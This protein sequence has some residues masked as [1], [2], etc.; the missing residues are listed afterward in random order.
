MELKMP[1]LLV[2]YRRPENAIRILESALNSGVKDFYVAVDGPRDGDVSNINDIYESYLSDFQK[3]YDVT[4]KV[5]Y[6]E[7]N[8]GLAVSMLTAIDWFFSEV[9]SGI[10]LEDDLEVGREFFEFMAS[11]LNY[12]KEQGEVLAISGNQFFPKTVSVSKI[13]KS[14]YPLIWGW[15]TWRDRWETFRNQLISGDLLQI[16]AALPRKVKYFWK[17]GCLR[18]LNS[19]SNSWAILL[20]SHSRFNNYVC[21]FPSSHLS[22]NIGSDDHATHTGGGHWTMNIALGKNLPSQYLLEGAECQNRALEK[23]VFEI[24]KRHNLLLVMIIL[25]NLL[26]P[27]DT[28]KSLIERLTLVVFPEMENPYVRK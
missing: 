2:T 9:D 13:A 16:D 12:Y 25:F 14:N 5:W 20:A 1:V 8:L 22:R 4:I 17:L 10:I 23:S 19:R 21:V 28:R 3:S 6:R 24:K 7:S 11:G 27:F 26:L 18:S 15:G